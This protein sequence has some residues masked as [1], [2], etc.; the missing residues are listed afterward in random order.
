[1]AVIHA[2]IFHEEFNKYMFN[3]WIDQLKLTIGVSGSVSGSLSLW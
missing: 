1:M 3:G 2:D